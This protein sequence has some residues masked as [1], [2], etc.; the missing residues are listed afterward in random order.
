MTPGTVV[1]LGDLLRRAI[2]FPRG[3]RNGSRTVGCRV[4]VRASRSGAR[5]AVLS[6]RSRAFPATYPPQSRGRP[7]LTLA[8]CASASP[9]RL[10]RVFLEM[11]TRCYGHRLARVA[12]MLDK[13]ARRPVSHRERVRQA[14][15]ARVDVRAADRHGRPSLIRW[16][17]GARRNPWRFLPHDAHRLLVMETPRP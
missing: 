4:R 8:W 2:A 7:R 16:R 14:G 9:S 13:A 10:T 6:R 5:R 17:G 1:G 11:P 12:V 3:R 15:F